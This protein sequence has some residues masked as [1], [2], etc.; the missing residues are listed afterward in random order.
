M[1]W[2]LSIVTTCALLSLENNW[3]SFIFIHDHSATCSRIIRPGSSFRFCLLHLPDIDKVIH[4]SKLQL[5]HL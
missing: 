5:L 2:A 1:K 4:D 3:C